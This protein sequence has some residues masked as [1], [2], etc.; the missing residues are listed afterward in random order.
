MGTGN[1]S[2]NLLVPP[3]AMV[4]MK[5]LTGSPAQW[6][7]RRNE[8]IDTR[9]RPDNR[10]MVGQDTMTAV[11]FRNYHVLVDKGLVH[12]ASPL[13]R[14]STCFLSPSYSFDCSADCTVPD[15]HMLQ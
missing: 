7:A 3:R 10:K 5:A 6:R 8:F 2:S 4:S 14:G 12:A 13:V 11:F 9:T 15:Q 1:G